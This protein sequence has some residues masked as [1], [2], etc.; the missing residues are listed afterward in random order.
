[1][2]FSFRKRAV[3]E[4]I[5]PASTS[6][7]SNEAAETT[8]TEALKTLKHFEEQHKLDP[9]L[10]VEE[11]NDVDAVLATGN[12]EKGVQIETNLLE[13]NSPYP[14]VGTFPLKN[15]PKW[16]RNLNA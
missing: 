14:E 6:S 12:A 13:E 4:E 9:N 3:A 1:M 8:G 15:L 11:L 10:P 16:F 5:S 2:G 7:S